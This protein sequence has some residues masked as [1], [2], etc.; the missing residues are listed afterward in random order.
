MD[1]QCTHTH[2]QTDK[3]VLNDS[4]VSTCSSCYYLVSRSILKFEGGSVE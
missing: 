3:Q 2:G 4:L 1:P